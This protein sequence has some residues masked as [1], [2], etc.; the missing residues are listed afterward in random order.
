MKELL[1]RP[2]RCLGC[3]SCELA[4]A[5]AHSTSKNLLTSISEEP[6]PQYRV[7]V[8]GDGKTSL[9]LQ[10][11][12]CEDAP[13]LNACLTGALHRDERDVVVCNSDL[14]VG[15]WMCIMVCPFGIINQEHK[16]RRIIKCDRCP[17]LETPACV[18]ACPTAALTYQEISEAGREKRQAVL[19]QLQQTSP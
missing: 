3:R 17:D 5:V 14:C 10:C 7:H 6:R 4:C 9:P 15:C 12:N 13:C 8:A 18:T 1:I 11:R 19:A 2:E 16:Q